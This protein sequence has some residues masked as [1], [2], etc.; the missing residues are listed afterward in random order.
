MIG[1][2][3]FE[4]TLLVMSY[5]CSFVTRLDLMPFPF[6]ASRR[7]CDALYKQFCI[8]VRMICRFGIR[9]AEP[10]RFTAPNKPKKVLSDFGADTMSLP[11]E[12]IV[13]FIRSRCCEGDYSVT[14]S[15]RNLIEQMTVVDIKN[16][17]R[18]HGISGY[19]G[20]NKSDLIDYVVGTRGNFS[21][22]A[23]A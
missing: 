7:L 17:C 18:Y 10:Q 2:K 12:A 15:R 11:K 4:K 5:T 16:L 21:C 6:S 3:T 22:S 13:K 23:R 14:G 8:E 20:M 19:S 1:L 9:V